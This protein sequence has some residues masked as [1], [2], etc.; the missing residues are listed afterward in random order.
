MLSTMTGCAWRPAYVHAHL[1]GIRRASLLCCC[2]MQAT[3]GLSVLLS[4]V[5]VAAHT[6]WLHLACQQPVALFIACWRVFPYAADDWQHRLADALTRIQ[7][8]EQQLQQAQDQ[9]ALLTT[10]AAAKDTQLHALHAEIQQLRLD[11]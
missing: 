11:R 8:L 10:A 1:F 6:R 7:Q 4:S 2:M 5:P 9:V 3:H